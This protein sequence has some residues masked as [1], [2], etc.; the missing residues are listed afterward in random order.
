MVERLA[1]TDR[2]TQRFYDIVKL[3]QI[4][5][6]RRIQVV[7]ASMCEFISEKLHVSQMNIVGVTTVYVTRIHY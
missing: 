2:R 5:I 4:K 6:C 7:S 3:C 1:R